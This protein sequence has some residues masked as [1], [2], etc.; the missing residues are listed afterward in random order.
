MSKLSRAV[1]RALGGLAVGPE[2]IDWQH[3]RGF[4]RASDA[5]VLPTDRL[6]WLAGAKDFDRVPPGG[7]GRWRFVGPAPLEV[8]CD[9]LYMGRGPNAGQVRDV[10]IDPTPGA[11]PTLYFAGNSAGVWKSEDGGLSWTALNDQLPTLRIG[12]LALDPDDPRIV[13]AGSGNLFDGSVGERRGAGLFKSVDGGRSWMPV[14]GGFDASPLCAGGV[15]RIV[16][17]DAQRVV[18]ATNDRLLLSEDGGASF[19]TQRLLHNGFIGHLALD[20]SQRRI[21]RVRGATGTPVRLRCTRHGWRD[22]DIVFVGGVTP[23]QMANGRFAVR[24]LGVDEVE[25]VGSLGSGADGT[26]GHALGPAHARSIVVTNATVPAANRPVELTAAG[27]GLVSGDI[28]AVHGVQGLNGANGSFA[29]DVLDANR[30]RLR[31]SRGNGAYTGGGTIDAADVPF[32]FAVAG[33]VD[34]PAGAIVTVHEHGFSVGDRTQLAGVANATGDVG[35]TRI[36]AVLDADRV[37]LRNVRLAGAYAG[38]GTLRRPP[39]T[40]NTL[41]YAVNGYWDTDTAFATRCPNRGLYRLALTSDGPVL[42]ANLL[43]N[44]GGFTADYNRIAFAQGGPGELRSLYALVQHGGVVGVTTTIRLRAFLSSQDG[45]ETWTQVGNL[46]TSTAGGEQNQS[47]YD[48]LLA[49]DP[50]NARRVYAGL[51]QVWVSENAGAAWPAPMP[52]DEGGVLN[53]IVNFERH[54]PSMGQT[55]FDQHAFASLPATFWPADPAA[56]V[57]VYAGSDGGLARSD[58]AGARW[59]PLNEGVGSALLLSLDLGRGVAGRGIAAV[60]MWDNG[61]A[62]LQPS[63]QAAGRWQLTNGD[64]GGAV[65]IDPFDPA[66]MFGVDNGNLVRSTNGG[67]SWVAQATAPWQASLPKELP[68]I[69]LRNANPTQVVARAHGLRTGDRLRFFD[70]QGAGGVLTGTRSITVVDADTL[71]VDGLNTAAAAAFVQP[72]RVVGARWRREFAVVAATLSSPIE[73]ETAEAHG[74]ATGDQV[75]VAAVAGPTQAN[76]TPARPWWAVTVIDAQRFSLDGSDASLAPPYRRGT[77]VVRGPRV[78]AQTVGITLAAPATSSGT[79]PGARPVVITAPGHGFVSGDTVTVSG[80]RVLTDANV[81]NHPITVLD[82]NSF[83][84]DALSSAQRSRPGARLRLPLVGNGLPGGG[85]LNSFMRIALVP[86]A[87]ARSTRVFVAVGTSL[88]RSDDGGVNFTRVFNGFPAAVTALHAPADNRLWVGFMVRRNNNALLPGEVWFS[89]DGGRTFLDAPARYVRRP[90]GRGSVAAIAEDP[91][92]PQRVAVA[93]AGYSHTD[94]QFRSRHVF[95]T[96][97]AGISA[98]GVHPWNELGGTSGAARGNLPDLPV[99][100][101]GFDT[102]STPSQLLAATDLGVLR[103]TATGWQRVGSNLPRVSCQALAVDATNLAQPL[104]RVATYG[105][106]VWEL[107]QPAAGRLDVICESAFTPTP[108]G[109]TSSRRLTL[110]NTGGAALQVTRLDFLLPSADITIVPAPVLPL[111]LA[112]GEAAEFELRYAPGSAGFR[113]PTLVIESNDPAQPRH[114]IELVARDGTPTRGLLGFTHRVRF[115]LTLVGRVR[116]LPIELH[117][118]SGQTVTVTGLDTFAPPAGLTVDPLDP[119]AAAAGQPQTLVLAPG[120]RA[121]RMVRYAPA[122]VAAAWRDTVMLSYNNAAGQGQTAEIIV[123]DGAA[124]SAGTD[125]LTSLLAALGLA[126][127]PEG[128]VLV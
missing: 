22:G 43:A 49:A 125:L 2:T 17:L 37:R 46:V 56:P 26:T 80:V 69:E 39:V 93:Y 104:L 48:L 110:H 12:A 94:P 83:A 35:G 98:G 4:A 71:S 109:T 47:S 99:L 106:G 77:G 70:V 119:V 60:G 63:R 59:Q 73:I 124:A 78:A 84:L 27:H 50:R 122:A 90:G 75:H 36:A 61:T 3:L 97:S 86:R 91:R 82:R 13:Y 79:S 117:N 126:D 57:P 100:G 95:E 118:R 16:A 102:T 64:D 32:D 108:I 116:T 52:R 45:G 42:S 41:L 103:Q 92:N 38:G 65:A 29:V 120:A 68:I 1:S 123:I 53:G 24:V 20:G 74:L 28:V 19:D 96:G 89:S 54:A 62:T 111:A 23:N 10:V 67:Q 5:L 101:L 127:A 88:Y 115:G 112:A 30:V 14:D 128:D 107:E 7:T 11:A 21:R 40:W 33:I 114:D 58:D 105:R 15:N 121:Q 51:K 55:H 44:T 85:S 8:E 18:V 87:G 72:P 31:G 76:N 113:R 81:T 9:Q 34:D 66:V 6:A 25:L